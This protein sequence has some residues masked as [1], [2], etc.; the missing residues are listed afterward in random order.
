MR[1]RVIKSIISTGSAARDFIREV[2]GSKSTPTPTV[3]ETT[4]TAGASKVL[5]IFRNHRRQRE[6]GYILTGRSVITAM[7]EQLRDYR[8]AGEQ[9]ADWVTRGSHVSVAGDDR[10]FTVIEIWWDREAIRVQDDE[11][12]D[13]M[14]PFRLIGPW[15]KEDDE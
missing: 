10:R 9:F 13:Y 11:G 7:D 5:E 1:A 8:S 2:C 4:R 15:P 3:A 6:P 12:H 14:I